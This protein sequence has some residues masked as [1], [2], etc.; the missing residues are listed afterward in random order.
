MKGKTF[1]YGIIVLLITFFC[2]IVASE[3]GYYEYELSK[4]TKL[5]NEKIEEFERD[6]KSGKKIDLNSYI[7]TK[8]NDY[9]NNISNLGNKLS[10][11]LENVFSKGFKYLFKYISNQIE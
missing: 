10:D 1:K 11:G 4:T 9:N 7:N 3:S 8:E 6:V 5:T 2:L